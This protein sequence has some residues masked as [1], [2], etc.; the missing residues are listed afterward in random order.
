MEFSSLIKGKSNE[1]SRSFV[2]IVYASF[3][4]VSFKT[5]AG[6]VAEK[7]LEFLLSCYLNYCKNWKC[8]YYFCYRH[9]KR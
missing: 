2:S 3:S 8:G 6:L 7:L 1:S 9:S 4:V 5:N